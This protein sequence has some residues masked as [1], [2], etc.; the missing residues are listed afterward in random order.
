MV[1]QQFSQQQKACSFV[2]LSYKIKTLNKLKHFEKGKILI[3]ENIL[4]IFIKLYFIL[5]SVPI[6]QVDRDKIRNSNSNSNKKENFISRPLIK[7][8]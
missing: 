6:C 2:S 3:D 8:P 5:H 4:N 1:N 7:T